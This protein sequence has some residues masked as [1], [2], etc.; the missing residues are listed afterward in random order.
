MEKTYLQFKTC[1]CGRPQ[2]Y[3]THLYCSIVASTRESLELNAARSTG[4]SRSTCSSQWCTSLSFTCSSKSPSGTRSELLPLCSLPSPCLPLPLRLLSPMLLPSIALSSLS[5]PFSPPAPLP[6][7]PLSLYPSRSCSLPAL[8]ALLPSPPVSPLP[9]YPYCCTGMPALSLLP[10]PPLPL[11]PPL[12]APLLSLPVLLC[13][14]SPLPP[15]SLSN[16]N[17]GAWL[18]A[19]RTRSARE[20]L[21]HAD[22]GGDWS[23]GA[24]RPEDAY[25][26]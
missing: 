13:S 21:D 16:E 22:V 6:R 23:D 17:G 1:R 4:N 7:P 20:S 25:S 12:P 5:L 10:P 26:N 24:G 18:A 19:G 9:C 14:L 15:F 11:H 8:S 2:Q 3:S